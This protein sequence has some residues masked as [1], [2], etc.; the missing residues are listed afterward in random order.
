MERAIKVFEQGIVA[1]G[2]LSKI[3]SDQSIDQMYPHPSSAH[4][5]PGC[6]LF[7]KKIKD[8]KKKHVNSY[9][10]STS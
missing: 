8:W 6:M 4:P 5:R 1:P 3:D 9:K 10:S 7:L 2:G